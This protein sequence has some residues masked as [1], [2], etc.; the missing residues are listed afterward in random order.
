MIDG[1]EALALPRAVGAPS[2]EVPEA[3]EGPWASQAAGVTQP[4]AGVGARW[5]LGS[6]SHSMFLWASIEAHCLWVFGGFLTCSAPIGVVS[7]PTRW[8]GAFPQPGEGCREEAA[9]QGAGDPRAG[10]G[11]PL[12]GE[13]RWG[14]TR[15]CFKAKAHIFL[16]NFQLAFFS[17]FVNKRELNCLN[18]T[19]KYLS[20]ALYFRLVFQLS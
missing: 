19:G 2:L 14:T 11:L 20:L 5:Y 1:G 15:S 7:D 4:L 3:M 6:L 17:V 18:P 8:S 12:G 13:L 16:Q 9:A 10:M